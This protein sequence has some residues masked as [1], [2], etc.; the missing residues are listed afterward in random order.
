MN[1]KGKNC[2]RNEASI[3][4]ILD[5]IF[6]NF[7]FIDNSANN[8]YHLTNHPQMKGRTKAKEQMK[9]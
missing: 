1:K 2:R 5:R 7:R 6:N 4:T 9:T 3:Y 8:G